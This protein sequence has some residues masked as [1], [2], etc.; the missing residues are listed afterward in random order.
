MAATAFTGKVSIVR[1][2]RST[3]DSAMPIHTGTGDTIRDEM[4][5]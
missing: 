2:G 5:R 3:D 4:R 1:P